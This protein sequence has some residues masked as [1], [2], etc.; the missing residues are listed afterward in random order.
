MME[1]T[2]ICDKG[3]LEEKLIQPHAVGNKASTVN[4]TTDFSKYCLLHVVNTHPDLC[5]AEGTRGRQLN[6]TNVSR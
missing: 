1:I 4:H 5:G 6:F 2:E 3:S